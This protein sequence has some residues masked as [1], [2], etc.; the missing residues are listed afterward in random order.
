MS[1]GAGAYAW[2]PV[3]VA[4]CLEEFGPRAGVDAVLW[5]DAGCALRSL[6]G[7]EG[8]GAP[9][10]EGA[11]ALVPAEKPSTRR[12]PG[13]PRLLSLRGLLKCRQAQGGT[14]K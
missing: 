6:S 9:T 4:A 13:A 1:R 7:R 14:V 3:I 5:L 10:G 11:P 12:P 2:K 8:R